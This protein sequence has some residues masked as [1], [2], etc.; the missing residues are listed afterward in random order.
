MRGLQ[1]RGLLLSGDSQVLHESGGQNGYC[2]K[3]EDD[4]A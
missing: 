3:A 1:W 2:G 4:T